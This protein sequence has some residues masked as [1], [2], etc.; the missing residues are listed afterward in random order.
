MNDEYEY[1][2]RSKGDFQPTLIKLIEAG[3]K[4][5]RIEIVD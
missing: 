5:I 1:T 3:Y 2:I 4:I